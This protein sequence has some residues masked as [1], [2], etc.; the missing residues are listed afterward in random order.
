MQ[1]QLS[2]ILYPAGL[3]EILMAALSFLGLTPPGHPML[4]SDGK[5][6]RSFKRLFEIFTLILAG[7]RISRA[8]TG[9]PATHSF[10]LM[11]HLLELSYFWIEA[12][13]RWKEGKL[14]AKCVILCAAVIPIPVMLIKTGPNHKDG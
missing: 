5:K 14:D 7:A 11:I 1:A 2:R 6:S 10:T 8:K 13:D 4:D 9:N 3:F 12:F